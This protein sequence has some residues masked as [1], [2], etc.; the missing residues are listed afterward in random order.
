MQ[1]YLPYRDYVLGDY[2]R[3]KK[4]LLN[5]D[6]NMVNKSRQVLREQ[7]VLSQQDLELNYTTLDK[8]KKLLEEQIISNRNTGN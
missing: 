7:E 3:R 5:K 8:N 6:I 4:D 2:A 1:S